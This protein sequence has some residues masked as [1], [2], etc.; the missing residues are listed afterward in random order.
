[1]FQVPWIVK[2]DVV[3]L[4]KFWRNYFGLLAVRRAVV[5]RA[6]D[7]VMKKPLVRVQKA[8]DY[9][10]KEGDYLLFLG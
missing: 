6:V 2:F 8:A 9:P 10:Q 1:M 7:W 4:E 3:R 5:K